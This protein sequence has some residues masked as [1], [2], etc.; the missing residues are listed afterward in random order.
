MSKR[1]SPYKNKKGDKLI[2]KSCLTCKYN[3]GPVCAS[4]GD[5]MLNNK[6]L[7]GQSIDECIKNFP[8]GCDD[9]VISFSAFIQQEQLNGR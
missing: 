1:Y 5:V 7:Y 9:W 4:H 3:F 8:D 6:D 2:K